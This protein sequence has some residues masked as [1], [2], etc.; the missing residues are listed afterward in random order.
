LSHE[1]ILFPKEKLCIRGHEWRLAR[2]DGD[3]SEGVVA[4]QPIP[5]VS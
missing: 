4:V 2:S 1:T 5:A 3:L